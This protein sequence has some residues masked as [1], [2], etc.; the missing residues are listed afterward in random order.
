V[1]RV[2]L[3]LPCVLALLLGVLWVRSYCRG[4]YCLIDYLPV[5]VKIEVESLEGLVSFECQDPAWSGECSFLTRMTGWRPPV[6][7]TTYG[8][9]LIVRYWLLA[10]LAL[11]WPLWQGWR[12]WQK[13]G[14]RLR[15]FPV[16]APSSCGASG[17][18][19]D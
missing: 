13:Q 19:S 5:H 12:W 11:A 2:L 17:R 9:T 1:K 10:V 6:V 3:I 15:G 7:F 4:D 14:S 16:E 8:S 18:G